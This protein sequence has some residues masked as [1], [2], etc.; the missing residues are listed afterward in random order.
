MFALEAESGGR[1]A[2]VGSPVL[3]TGVGKINAAWALTRALARSRPRLVVNFGTAGS[4][5]FATHAL[6]GCT[7]FLQRDM[8]V[9]PLGVPLGTTPFDDVPAELTARHRFAELPEG[10][11]GSADHFVAG[12]DVG[13]SDVVDMEAYAL[14]KVCRLE[15][16][17]FA[18]AK[19]VTDGADHSAHHDW[20][21]NLPR[22]AAGFRALYDRLVGR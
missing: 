11:C 8:D 17:E 12:H 1:F 4:P 10:T 20:A 22:A 7:R 18:A 5:R 16:V 15:G 3:Y 19:Y 2:D 13:A 9:R 6:V 21:A 14:A